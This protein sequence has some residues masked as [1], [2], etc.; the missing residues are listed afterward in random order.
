MKFT[1]TGNFDGHTISRYLGVVNGEVILGANVFK[2]L[3]ST[4]RDFVG[5]RS[6]TYE[7]ELEKGRRMALD[8][9]GERAR[10]LGANAVVGIRFDYGTIGASG[11]MMMICV[12]GTAVVVDGLVGH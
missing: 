12:S 7:N 2:D 6:A 4:V 9:L 8:E 11:S 10:V 3:L 1:T 5:G